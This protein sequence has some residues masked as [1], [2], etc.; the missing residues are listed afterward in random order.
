VGYVSILEA[1]TEL[2]WKTASFLAVRLHIELDL[3]SQA[4]MCSPMAANVDILN[5]LPHYRYE[6]E[7][8]VIYTPC[9]KTQNA[10]YNEI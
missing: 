10:W 6:E 2:L 5:I 9:K 8:L 3:K 7:H 1:M 4:T